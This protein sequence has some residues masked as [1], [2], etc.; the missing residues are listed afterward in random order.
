MFAG[1][2]GRAIDRP[3]HRAT[4]NSHSHFATPRIVHVASSANDSPVWAPLYLTPDASC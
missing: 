4:R 1:D 3:T 2:Q